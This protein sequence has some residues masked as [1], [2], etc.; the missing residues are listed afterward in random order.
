[1]RRWK[2]EVK[3]WVLD[4]RASEALSVL[5]LVWLTTQARRRLM[6]HSTTQHNAAQRSKVQGRQAGFPNSG[7]AGAGAWCSREGKGGAAERGL[8]LGLCPW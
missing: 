1:M 6:Q 5:V 3:S 8:G 2:S 7:G 4:S